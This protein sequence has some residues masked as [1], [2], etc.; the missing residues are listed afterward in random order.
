MRKYFIVSLCKN[1]ILGGGIT[2]DS[3]AITF[4]TGK[5]TIPQKYRHLVMPY[6]D[7]CGLEVG[8]LFV[9]P[10]VSVKMCDGEEYRF[11][12]FNRGRF[13]NTVKTY[14]KEVKFDGRKV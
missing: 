13:V 11:V 6:K 2:A 12:V 4:H 7:I 14:V 3:D 9:L 10:T 8:W 1:G 5:V